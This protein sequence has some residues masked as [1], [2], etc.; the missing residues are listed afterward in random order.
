LTFGGQY[1]PAKWI[2]AI[3]F[4]SLGKTI[5]FDDGNLLK[6]DHELNLRI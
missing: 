2:K 1:D 3:G 5:Y 6:I 4:F